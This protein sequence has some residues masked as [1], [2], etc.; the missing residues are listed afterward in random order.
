MDVASG[1]VLGG[2]GLRAGLANIPEVL[3]GNPDSEPFVT[4]GSLLAVRAI[5]ENLVY[6]VASKLE[7]HLATLTTAFSHLFS[8]FLHVKGMVGPILPNLMAVMELK[9]M[10]RATMK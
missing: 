9:R 6:G 7:T 3:N 1:I 10:L 2:I 8:P 4:A 5:A